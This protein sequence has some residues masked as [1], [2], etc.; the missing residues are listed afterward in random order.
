MMLAG[1]ILAAGRANRMGEDKR[2]IRVGGRSMLDHAIDAA[3]G[4]GLS[5]VLVVTGPE[6]Q[7]EL[8]P[9]VTRVIN[10]NP[11][12]G[13]ASSLAAGIAALPGDVE[14][15]M[16]LLADMPKVSGTHVATL[17]AAFTPH[18]ICIPVFGGRRG[19]PV[20]FGRSYF[21]AMRGLTGDKGA[22]VLIA[23]HAGSVVEVPVGDE[24]ILI[25]VDTPEALRAVGGEI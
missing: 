16:V 5:P 25:D 14:G 4:G 11:A 8:P 20:L 15:V 7:P 22:R 3:L 12:R 17:V 1:L 2:L 18:G 23:E 13:M 19:N 21:S 10:E 9:E 24:G 6:A